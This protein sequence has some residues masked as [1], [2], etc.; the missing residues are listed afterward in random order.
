LEPYWTRPK[1]IFDA[2]GSA[3]SGYGMSLFPGDDS[4]ALAQEAFATRTFRFFLSMR[5]SPLQKS[6]MN[7][8]PN[9]TSTTSF[10]PSLFDGLYYSIFDYGNEDSGFYAPNSRLAKRVSAGMDDRSIQCPTHMSGS[11]RYLQEM[12]WKNS[13]K[14]MRLHLH[15]SPNGEKRLPNQAS[16]NRKVHVK[17]IKIIRKEQGLQIFAILDRQHSDEKRKKKI[18]SPETSEEQTN[19]RTEIASR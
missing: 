12:E 15:E 3:G 11:S 4:S 17:T 9:Q 18:S 8:G 14:K 2:E 16:L 5:T 1:D 6:V 13:I 10:T 19:T 7:T